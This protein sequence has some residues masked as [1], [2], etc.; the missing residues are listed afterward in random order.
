MLTE[1]IITIT[2][3]LTAS[4]S[5]FDDFVASDDFI[6][7]GLIQTVID[8]DSIGFSQYVATLGW[9]QTESN[10][11]FS[12]IQ[13]TASPQLGPGLAFAQFEVRHTIVTN[14][15]FESIAL[16]EIVLSRNIKLADQGGIKFDYPGIYKVTVQFR[17]T[18]GTNAQ[19][20]ARS[21]IIG[22]VNNDIVGRSV[23]YTTGFTMPNFYAGPNTPSGLNTPSFFIDIQDVSDIYMLQL[24]RDGGDSSHYSIVHWDSW[25]ETDPVEWDANIVVLVEN[26]GQL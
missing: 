3:I 1:L 20:I 5:I 2:I 4:G 9:N 8:D 21:Q 26:I 13:L 16:D 22:L 14:D 10:I 25:S 7:S 6:K 15:V 19:K 17:Q 24:V 23:L 18:W 12:F 11:L